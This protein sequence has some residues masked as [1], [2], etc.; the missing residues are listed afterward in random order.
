VL[1]ERARVGRQGLSVDDEDRWVFNRMAEA[2]A[3]RPPYPPGLVDRLAALATGPVVELGAGMGH[4]AV[5]LAARGRRV[6]AV[7][8]ARRML[9]RLTSR[10]QPGVEAVHATA[11]DTGLPPG[12]FALV[13]LADALHWVD[14]ERTGR[15]SKR[16]LAP[17]GIL[18][19]LE[20]KAG[21]NAF[22]DGVGRLLEATNP[23]ARQKR[24]GA[25]RQL[26]T[27]AV[28]R[29]PIATETWLDE[30]PLAPAALEHFLRSLSFAGPALSPQAFER[31]LTAARE[32]AGPYP[33]WRRELTLRWAAA[34][35]AP[36]PFGLLK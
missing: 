14:P 8:P 18:A 17:G 35:G 34:S 6:T 15:E 28:G 21:G 16:L 9:E 25:G 27:L 2:Y 10:R 5:P 32:L 26:F 1:T 33:L 3:A 13:L 7:E 30:A 22:T 19:V 11:E 20:A 4:L 31:L 36:V 23:K 24:T 12:G 29:R